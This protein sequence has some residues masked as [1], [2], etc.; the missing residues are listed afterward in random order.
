MC[1]CFSQMNLKST[2]EKL[3]DV[4]PQQIT[5]KC[6]SE[7]ENLPLVLTFLAGLMVSQLH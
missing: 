4:L 5:Q 3:C 2:L 6:R 1:A 7:V